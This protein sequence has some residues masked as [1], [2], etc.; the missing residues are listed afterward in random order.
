MVLRDPPDLIVLDIMMPGLDGS[1]LATL[2]GNLR[3][4]R[5][6]QIV[7]WSAADAHTLRTLSARTGFRTF[8]KTTSLNDLASKLEK[9]VPVE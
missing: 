2:I 6:P 7:F 9:I 5:N 4:K 1:Q 8:A 3:L